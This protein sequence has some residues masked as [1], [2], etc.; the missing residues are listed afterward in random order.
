GIRD[1]TVTGVQTCALPIFSKTGATADSGAPSA[2]ASVVRLGGQPL[3]GLGGTQSGD[4]EAAGSL[5]DTGTSLP[6]RVQVAPWHAEADGRSEE[7]RV[8]KECRSG[9]TQ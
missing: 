1:R 4:G 2:D 6:A 8:G 9:S 3:L 5:L 7:R